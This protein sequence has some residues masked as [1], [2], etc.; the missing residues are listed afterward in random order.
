MTRI[1]ISDQAYPELAMAALR[2]ELRRLE[3]RQQH[4][5]AVRR[6]RRARWA[7]VARR[8]KSLVAQRR[9]LVE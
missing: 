9:S 8:L 5:D 4:V 6:R 7:A 2:E 3:R 1:E